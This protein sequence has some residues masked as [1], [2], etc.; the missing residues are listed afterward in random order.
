MK[1]NLKLLLISTF[2]LLNS[3]ASTVEKISYDLVYNINFDVSK[4]NSP[5]EN[6]VLKRKIYISDENKNLKFEDEF[7]STEWDFDR[8]GFWVHIANKTDQKIKILWNNSYFSDNE[9]GSINLKK[10]NFDK[11]KSVSV[12]IPESFYENMIYPYKSSKYSYFPEKITTVKNIKSDILYKKIESIYDKFI[13]KPVQLLIPVEINNQV[14]EY[15]FIFKVNE[16]T[17]E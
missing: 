2:L 12:I 14:Y 16:I 10:Y 5:K 8:E 17:I 11:Y 13:D 1:K 4:N 7:I 6:I 3:C 9:S 15:R